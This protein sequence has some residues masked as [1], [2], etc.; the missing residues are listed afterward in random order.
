LEK[1]ACVRTYCK[2]HYGKR[3]NRRSGGGVRGAVGMSAMESFRSAAG[4]CKQGKGREIFNQLID[5][6]S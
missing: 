3:L 2:V 1:K 5:Y 6:S 4:S